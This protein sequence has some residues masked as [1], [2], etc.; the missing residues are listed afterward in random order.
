MVSAQDEFVQA[1]PENAADIDYIWVSRP[2][3]KTK[4]K[5][6]WALP[7]QGSR[8]YHVSAVELLLRSG[9]ATY[10]DLGLGLRASAHLSPE[11]FRAPLDQIEQAL[12]EH[13]RKLAVNSWL[14]ALQCSETRWRVFTGSRDLEVPFTGRV[15]TREAPGGYDHC[16]QI[17]VASL[18]S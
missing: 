10:A 5:Q 6:L 13:L 9:R 3:P 14:G 8:F 17:Q 1:T 2:T 7:F 12:P 11:V 18:H 4:A 16:C 15:L